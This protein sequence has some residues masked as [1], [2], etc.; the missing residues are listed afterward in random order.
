MT[1]TATVPLSPL[2][3]RLSAAA[4]EAPRLKNPA[5][6]A[7]AGAVHVHGVRW[8]GGGARSRRR[9]CRAAVVEEAGAR[10]DGVL[11]P[12][13][14][15]DA[16][17]AAAGRYDWKEEWYPL[18][19]AKEVP[20]DAALPLTVFDRQLVLWRDGDGVLRCHQDRCPHR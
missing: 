9:R 16:A 5:A 11:L 20:D 13:E 1:P 19:L 17:A 12:K 15:D 3:L 18:Y 6:T 8:A 4:A 14:G 10:E 2:L 7:A